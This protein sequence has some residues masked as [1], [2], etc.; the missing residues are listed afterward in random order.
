MFEYLDREKK[1]Y[2]SYID[3]CE[4]AE[5]RRR[6]LDVFNYELAEQQKKAE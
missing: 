2:L 1:N 5:E 3:F 6:K 4:M